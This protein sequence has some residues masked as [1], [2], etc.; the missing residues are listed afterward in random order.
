MKFRYTLLIC[1]T[2]IGFVGCDGGGEPS[3]I[4]EGMSDSDRQAEID[5]YNKMNETYAAEDAAEDAAEQEE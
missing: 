5:N 4:L 2:L 1:F 3:S